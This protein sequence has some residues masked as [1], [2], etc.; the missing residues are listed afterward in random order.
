MHLSILLLLHSFEPFKVYYEYWRAFKYLKLFDSLLVH[1]T[2][3]A[4]PC[5]LVR[6][7]LRGHELPEAVVNHHLI[8]LKQV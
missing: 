7:F 3:T 2:S 6:E 1:L 4:K 8:V 5:V